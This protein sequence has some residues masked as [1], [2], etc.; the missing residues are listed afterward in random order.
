VV[1][2][3]AFR[4]D[5]EIAGDCGGTRNDPGIIPWVFSHWKAFEVLVASESRGESE[6]NGEKSLNSV[7]VMYFVAVTVCLEFV[8]L[9]VGTLKSSRATL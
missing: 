9:V 4:N 3:I 6:D 5:A 2:E 8:A 7:M 1:L